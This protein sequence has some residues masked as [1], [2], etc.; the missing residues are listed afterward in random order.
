VPTVLIGKRDQRK[1]ENKKSIL[2]CD[3]TEDVCIE[4]AKVTCAAESV[5]SCIEKKEIG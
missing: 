3:H 4:G 5:G 2:K 1:N